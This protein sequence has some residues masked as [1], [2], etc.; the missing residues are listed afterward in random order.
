VIVIALDFSK[1]FD[2]VRHASLFQ[3]LA[4]LRLPEEV[5]NWMVDFFS[6][7]SHCTKFGG[8]TYAFAD[9][10]ASVIQG[11]ALGPASY[12]V[13]AADLHPVHDGNAMVKF[14]DDTY[15][16]IPAVNHHTSE[17]EL[18]NVEAWA[19]AN[20]L[21]LNQAKSVEIIFHNPDKK[22]GRK[23]IPPAS[24]GLTRAD[25][26]TA[27][28]VELTNNFSMRKHVD[29]LLTSCNQTLFAVRTLR[30]HGLSN[31]S[32][33]AI[34]ASVA[35]GKLRYAAPA[36]YGFTSAEDRERLEVLLRKSKRAG[37]CAPTT[38]TFSSMCADADN[39]LFASMRADTRHVLHKLLPLRAS[40]TYNLRP[41]AHDFAIPQRTSSL[42]DK[43]FLTRML[44][45]GL[46]VC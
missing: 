11:S 12:L 45:S 30:A 27:L 14:A 3:K 24:P 5:F 23:D 43:N 6:N 41:R 28:G 20:N 21:R 39:T 36:W 35:L 15:L 9:I 13:N 31:E 34:F 46:T 22:K 29:Q 7:H 2:T 4:D 40:R 33:H 1:A 38:P 16:I 44:Y 37:Y 10:N 18:R 32:L 26:I 19:V 25:T 17:S 8:E 42:A